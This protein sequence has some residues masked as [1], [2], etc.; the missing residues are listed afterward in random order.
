M[1]V[2]VRSLIVVA[3]FFAVTALA[4]RQSAARTSLDFMLLNEYLVAIPIELNGKGPF[5]FILDTGTETTIV[6]PEVAN[7]LGLQIVDR[8]RLIT[9]D[10]ERVAA[11]AYVEGI[12]FGAKDKHHIEVLCDDLTALRA[13]DPE[14]VG[15]LGQNVLSQSNYLID[16]DHRQISFPGDGE[17]KDRWRGTR[18]KT[19]SAGEKIILTTEVTAPIKTTMRLALDSSAPDLVLF[20][21][22][23]E[24][25]KMITTP[26]QWQPTRGDGT[27]ALIRT[28]VPSLRVGEFYLTNLAALVIPNPTLLEQ[29]AEDGLLPTRFFHRVLIQN[30]QHIV[31]LNP[32]AK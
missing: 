9:V 30:D 24:L 8:M 31:M 17:W 19:E 5:R 7:Q 28:S 16:Y 11:R 4:P 21:S 13:I 15:I 27:T 2:N 3:V 23:Q 14:I 26:A 32:T 12:T 25:L 10:G 22:K 6:T 18:L 20:G 29:R 1:K